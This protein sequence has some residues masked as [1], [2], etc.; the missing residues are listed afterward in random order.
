MLFE[1]ADAS[2]GQSNFPL[3]ILGEL[4]QNFDLDLLAIAIGLKAMGTN[5]EQQFDDF[6]IPLL[7]KKFSGQ[8]NNY[9]IYA[10]LDISKQNYEEKTQ[11]LFIETL[12]GRPQD[13]LI[14]AL[15]TALPLPGMF[16]CIK[17]K[18]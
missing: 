18:D 7:T 11:N 5:W 16:L 1:T 6:L 4:I 15:M 14:L 8:I 2:P 3:V 12:S 9:G 10:L 13:F 17:I